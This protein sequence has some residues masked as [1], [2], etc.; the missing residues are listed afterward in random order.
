[1]IFNE[2]A[3]EKVTWHWSQRV[4]LYR[5]LPGWFNLFNLIKNPELS[6]LFTFCLTLLSKHSYYWS[7]HWKDGR[8]PDTTSCQYVHIFSQVRPGLEHAAS[9]AFQCIHLGP[10]NPSFKEY[11]QHGWKQISWLGIWLLHGS[12]LIDQNKKTQCF[13][14]LS[15]VCT[16]SPYQ[17]R[18]K[19]RNLDSKS[20]LWMTEQPRLS[21]FR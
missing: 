6:E 21:Q 20:Y 15:W 7:W 9:M 2:K 11:T 12:H 10:R 17:N 4:K 16:T 3:S 18:L 19:F 1:M 5:E 8:T 13:I 14:C